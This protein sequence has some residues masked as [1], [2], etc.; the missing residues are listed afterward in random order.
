MDLGVRLQKIADMILPCDILAD[1]G[2]DHGYLSVYLV[3]KEKCKHVI[4]MDIH[5]GP[6]QKARDN[7]E[8]FG[9][10]D[11]IETRLS[12]GLQK[13]LQEEADACVCAGM[14]GPLAL[15]ILW[16]DRE[17]VKKMKQ[18]VLQPQSELWF[19]RRT[20]REWGLVIEKEDVVKEDGKYYFIMR[21]NPSDAVFADAFST[22]G[23]EKKNL[24][25]EELLPETLL[26]EKH[27][28]LKEYMDK[29][30]ARLKRVLQTLS[31]QNNSVKSQTKKM[32]IEEEL[33]IYNEAMKQYEA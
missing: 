16:N 18:I 12:D 11:Y 17:K 27:P 8:K 21:L 33:A 10:R 15:Q 28:I 20:L 3:K 31:E 22:M 6:L 2:C 25:K 7:I 24:Q 26:K 14:G 5:K 13:A 32:E 1:V 4:A 30:R 19:V 9:C 29:E 23:P